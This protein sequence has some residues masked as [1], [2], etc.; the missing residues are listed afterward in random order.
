MQIDDIDV[1][2]LK[3]DALRKQIAIVKGVEIFEGT[4]L[5]NVCVGRADVTLADARNALA[6]VDVLET[7]LAIPKGI[8]TH[9][10]PGG[11][12]LSL[13]ATER[14]VLARAIAG[15]PRLLVL[16]ET[17]DNMDR[18]IRDRVWS[19]ITGQKAPWTLL[20]VTHNDDVAK[21]MDRQIRLERTPTQEL[22]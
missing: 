17:L 1:R 13:G 7:I 15:R 2:D 4:I 22:S 5:E 21:R 10:T 8:H 18:E 11:H 6:S 9:L 19:V 14:V 16:D 12:P 3:L 20:V